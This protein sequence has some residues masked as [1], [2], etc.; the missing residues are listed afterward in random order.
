MEKSIGYDLYIEN[1]ANAGVLAEFEKINERQTKQMQVR[2]SLYIVKIIELLVKLLYVF[3]ATP[4]LYSIIKCNIN[5]VLYY[6]VLNIVLFIIKVM[7]S[8]N[9]VEN[10]CI[11]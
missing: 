1:E 9:S 3:M 2:A 4:F 6:Q 5:K 8:R 11:I 10:R 7:K